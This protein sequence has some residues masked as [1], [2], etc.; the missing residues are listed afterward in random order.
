MGGKTKDSYEDREGLVWALNGL[1]ISQVSTVVATVAITAFLG[2]TLKAD[3][4]KDLT[5]GATT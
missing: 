5:D 4:M 1:L 3:K 2:V